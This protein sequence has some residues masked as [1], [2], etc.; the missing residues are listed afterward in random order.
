MNYVMG[1]YL[2]SFLF[3][4]IGHASFIW[5]HVVPVIQGGNGPVLLRTPEATS[6]LT[7]TL[8]IVAWLLFTAWDMRRVSTT[9]LTLRIA[10]ALIGLGT[11]LFGPGNTLIGAWGWREQ[12]WEK[13]RWRISDD[14]YTKGKA[15]VA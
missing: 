13:S 1:T 3:A 6:F 8:L 7:F 15:D 9:T 14:R 11:I 12:V 10:A 4:S 5:T 2:T